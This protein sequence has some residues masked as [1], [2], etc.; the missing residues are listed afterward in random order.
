VEDQFDYNSCSFR[1]NIQL[2]G[3]LAF[4][5]G[6]KLQ[7]PCLS[8]FSMNSSGVIEPGTGGGHSNLIEM[9]GEIIWKAGDGILTG[10]KCF[11]PGA[12][13]GCVSSLPIELT[14]FSAEQTFDG[15]IQLKWITASEINNDYFEIQRSSDAHYYDA[16]AKI[17]GGGNSSSPRYYS[18]N[19]TSDGIH[20]LL[21]YKIRQVDF[22]GSYRTYGPYTVRLQ[23]PQKVFAI[24]P[25]PLPGGSKACMWL[26][27]PRGP[28][29][30]ILMDIAGRT[31]FSLDFSADNFSDVHCFMLPGLSPGT[32]TG[33]LINDQSISR[34]RIVITN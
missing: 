25:N 14:S 5:T 20:N 30:M 9:C 32:Y 12:G 10:P 27:N 19:D 29:K 18:Y 3:R 34:D 21:Y 4:V 6:K 16:I 11:S 22:N 28:V 17:K 31:V 24:R 15:S 33:L 8:I 23:P 1:I 2:S 26:N 13:P 7:M